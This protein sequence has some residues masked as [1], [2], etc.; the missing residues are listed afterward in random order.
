MKTV[1]HAI[2]IIVIII[3]II[4]IIII[5]MKNFN[6]R[7]SHGHHGS[8]RRNP[9]TLWTVPALVHVQVWVHILSDLHSVQLRNAT[10]TTSLLRCWYTKKAHTIQK[11][12]GQALQSYQSQGQVQCLPSI[13]MPTKFECSSLNLVRYIAS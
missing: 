9:L 10:Q 6:R 2:I 5:I 7:D 3:T 1:V 8:K 4:I 13:V 11:E 12:E